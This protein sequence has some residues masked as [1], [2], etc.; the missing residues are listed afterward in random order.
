MAGTVSEQITAQEAQVKQTEAKKQNIQAQLTKTAIRSPINGIITNQ[1][2]K[3]GE[4]ISANT[5]IVSVIS[6]A[7]WEIKTDVPEADIAKIEIGD[8]AKLTLDAYGEDVKFSAT[9]IL[10]DPAET[11]IEGVSNYKVTLHFDE[12]DE[13]IRSGMTANLDILTAEKENVIAI[14]QRAVIS[15]NGDKIVRILK[16]DETIEEVNVITGIRGS[17]GNIEIIKGISE[18]D[19]VIIFMK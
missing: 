18:G 6:E 8:K 9:V 13:R 10:I 12:K 17:Y 19:R 15:K 3:V 4:I 7:N 5:A 1:D 2:T 16:D 14:P 11:V